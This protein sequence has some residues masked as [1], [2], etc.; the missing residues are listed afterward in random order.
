MIEAPSKNTAD[1]NEKFDSVV[2]NVTNPVMYIL[3]KDYE[4]YPEYLITFK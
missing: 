1:P 2:D 3:F 4:Y